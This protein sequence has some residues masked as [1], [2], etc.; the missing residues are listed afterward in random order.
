MN[1][2]QSWGQYPQSSPHAVQPVLWQS[3]TIDFNAPHQTYLPY[4]SGRSYG[5]SCLNNGGTLL[6]V[7]PL[8]RMLAF[9]ELAGIF[10]C[11]AG[12]SFAEILQII[13]PKGWFL[14]V[15]PGTQ[16]VSVGGAVAND[17]HGKN[18]HR[19]GTFGVHVNAFEL[20]RSS[21]ERLV[22]SRN[23]N[24]EL[25]SATIGGLGLTG[26]MLWVEFQL[27][28]IA[29]P[30]IET[31][32]T[33]FNHL[34]EFFSLSA[35]A[36]Q[37]SEYSVAWI[38][39]FASKKDQGRGIFITGNHQQQSTVTPSSFPSHRTFSVPCN[40]PTFLLNQY[41]LRLCNTLNFHLSSR[42]PTKNIEPFDTFFYPLDR[43][44]HWN[45]LYGARGFLQY[46][47]VMPPSNQETGIAEL[48][49]QIRQSGQGSFLAVLKQFGSIASPG[50]M[51]FP[52][53]GTT[54]AL[55]FPNRG[56]DTFNLL[57][58]LDEIVCE[59]GGVVYPAKD[60]RMSAQHFRSYF[61]LWKTFAPWID[62]KFSSSFWQRV[63]ATDDPSK[64]LRTLNI[65]NPLP[66]QHEKLSMQFSP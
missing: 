17:V 12:V 3:D 66:A 40:A 38:D 42:T 10:R 61:P 28:P 23:Q 15:T 8:K 45:R 49:T 13:V 7:R 18:H 43:L 55:D 53:E 64:D 39:C 24:A 37:H 11:E 33:R 41:S 52:R 63:M 32:R 5:D 62:P 31:E 25:F 2:Y 51:S 16:H 1:Q 60:A 22:C 59:C 35:H 21:G 56:E 26:V 57:Q 14:P 65:Q 6:D 20:L 29:G 36:D 46:Q 27:T 44:L 30:W 19:A 58:T 34:T 4:A 50:L 48:L 47:C 54:L 9:D